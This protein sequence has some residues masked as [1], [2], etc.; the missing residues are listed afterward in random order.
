MSGGIYYETRLQRVGRY[1]TKKMRGPYFGNLPCYAV[2]FVR[3]NNGGTEV[4]SDFDAGYMSI[5]V[6]S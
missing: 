3:L 1:I 2:S 4:T 5:I 6:L